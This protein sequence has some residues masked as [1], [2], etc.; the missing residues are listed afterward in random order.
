[1]MAGAASLSFTGC[2]KA[3][4]GVAQV[5][6]GP[7][8]SAEETAPFASA[9][10]FLPKRKPGLWKQTVSASGMVQVSRICL[11]K[12]AEARLA[13]WG[14]QTGEDI[15]AEQE[16]RKEAGGWAFN[17]RCDMGSGGTVVSRG[18]AKGDFDSN[19]TVQVQS[20]TSGAS[21]PQMN[22]VHTASISSVW[23]GP[24][25]AGMKPGDME[26]PNGMKINML[27]LGVR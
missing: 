24:C 22:G 18:T 21:A 13:I 4:E 17:S 1:M 9:P 12:D 19:Y 27:T 14:A 16:V 5:A 15:C 7:A 3:P 2:S 26:L 10:A 11:D 6:S 8:P 20:T 23:L 25:P